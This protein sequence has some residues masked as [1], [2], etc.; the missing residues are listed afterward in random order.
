M[1]DKLVSDDMRRCYKCD[2][3]TLEVV[4]TCPKCGAG[5]FSTKQVRR[6]GWVL[7]VIGLFL[8]GLM[9]FITYHLAPSMLRPGVP[10]PGSTTFSGTAEQGVRSLFLF[11]TVI[12]FGLAAG[13]IGLLQIK[14]GR[15]NKWMLYF[16]LGLLALVVVS[17]WRTLSVFG[18]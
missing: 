7:L 6:R 16:F 12:A 3:E 4:P 1:P 18:H 15:R 9:G 8:V 11:G 13:V 2:F 10:I 5:L 14:T 17:L